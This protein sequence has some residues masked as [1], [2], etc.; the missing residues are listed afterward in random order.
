MANAKAATIIVNI[1]E[2]VLAVISALG[3]FYITKAV[4]NPA[5]CQKELNTDNRKM[6]VRVALVLI[7]IQVAFSLLASAMNMFGQRN[8]MGASN[9]TTPMGTALISAFR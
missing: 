3:I 1:V 6:M 2:I 8:M 9:S 4:W 5:N 7:W